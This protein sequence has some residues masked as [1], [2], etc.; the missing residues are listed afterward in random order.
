MNQ[1][2]P[3]EFDAMTAVHIPMSERVMDKLADILY[4]TDELLSLVRV[5][6]RL[7]DPTTSAVEASMSHVYEQINE[8]MKRFSD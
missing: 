2:A 8:L 6:E 3:F 7:P 4:A 1:K 5:E